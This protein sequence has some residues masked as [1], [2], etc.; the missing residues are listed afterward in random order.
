MPYPGIVALALS[1]PIA[2]PHIAH[3][4]GCINIIATYSRFTTGFHEAE[5]RFHGKSEGSNAGK[6]ESSMET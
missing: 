6:L 2:T 5:K 3:V 4:H 1:F